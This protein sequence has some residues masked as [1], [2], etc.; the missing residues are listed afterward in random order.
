MNPKKLTAA[1]LPPAPTGQMP[2]KLATDLRMVND[3]LRNALRAAEGA[4]TEAARARRVAEQL[5]IKYDAL[6]QEAGG[7]GR[8]P[9]DG[10][11]DSK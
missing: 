2:T 4:E 8:L 6:V 1:T 9:L 7:Q 5:T 11:D 3:Q 10:E